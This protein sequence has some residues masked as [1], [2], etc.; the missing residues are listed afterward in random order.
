MHDVVSIAI[1]KG[2]TKE[3][4]RLGVGGQR[5]RYR[6]PVVGE[7]RVIGLWTATRPDRP[8]RF[9]QRLVDVAVGLAFLCETRVPEARV[10][11]YRGMGRLRVVGETCLA[12]WREQQAEGKFQRCFIR[13]W[14]L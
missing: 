3:L 6:V 14:L 7:H 12:A 2:L 5:L 8:N 4:E 9:V 13:C 10:P 1:V 11:C